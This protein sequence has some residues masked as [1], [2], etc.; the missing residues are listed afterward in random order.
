M[1][2]KDDLQNLGGD[3]DLSQ[4]LFLLELSFGLPDIVP[5]LGITL[6]QLR[7]SNDAITSTINNMFLS[8]TVSAPA[9][10]NMIKGKWVIDL[11]RISATTDLG[12]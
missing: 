11:E 12:R 4:H 8:L 2:E 6:E 5:S 7:A 9:D 3:L 10:R 1:A